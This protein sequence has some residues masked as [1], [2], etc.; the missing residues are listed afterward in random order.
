[1]GLIVRGISTV[2]DDIWTDLVGSLE[3]GLNAKLEIHL[4]HSNAVHILCRAG[5]ILA[6]VTWKHDLL[7]LSINMWY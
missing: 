4:R 3:R 6:A 1:M 7:P 5:T 2:V